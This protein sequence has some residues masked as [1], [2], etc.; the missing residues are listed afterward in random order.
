MVVA[1][2]HHHKPGATA[3]LT[4][5]LEDLRAN[6]LVWIYDE[7]RGAVCERRTILSDRTDQSDV[8][9]GPAK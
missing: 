5:S 2:P 7:K 3:G 9:L 4:S 6:D 8:I 1:P